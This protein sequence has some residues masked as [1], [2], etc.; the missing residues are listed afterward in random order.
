MLDFRYQAQTNLDVIDDVTERQCK[1]LFYEMFL[2]RKELIDIREELDEIRAWKD[3]H[4]YN[5]ESKLD[6]ALD[7][8]YSDHVGMFGNPEFIPQSPINQIIADYAS[9][10]AGSSIISTPDTVSYLSHFDGFRFFGTIDWM[11]ESQPHTILQPTLPGK[12][13]A[14]YGD[15]GRIIIKLG[16]PVVVT[17]VSLEH[18]RIGEGVN[19]APKD[20]QI[21][22]LG[23][24]FAENLGYFVYDLKDKIIQTFKIMSKNQ[25][26]NSVELRILSNYGN[27]ELTCVYRFRVHSVFN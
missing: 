13:Y 17:H 5:F 4:L 11:L 25:T 27:E 6:D 22:G 8:F 20:F 12:C 21:L 15:K 18:L 3:D 1:Q 23:D 14:F 24:G 19:S 2:L 26:V 9:E 10:Y 16:S 7:V